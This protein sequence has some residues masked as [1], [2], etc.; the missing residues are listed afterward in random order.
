MPHH[1]WVETVNTSVYIM[2]R[3]PIV[4]VL[5]V[6]PEEKH[7]GRKLDLSHLKVFGCIAYVHILDELHTKLDPKAKKC[8]FVDYLVEQKGYKCYNPSTCELRVSRDVVFDEMAGWY[9]DIKDI[10][11]A[12]VKEPVDASSG[13]QESQ[14][15]SGP[16]ESSSSGSTNMPWC[17]GI[18]LITLIIAEDE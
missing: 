3:T 13:K 1:F 9:S 5:G 14:T 10:I 11:G 2:N 18:C 4:A 8:I 15:L 16:R 12:D 6:T 17:N 7:S